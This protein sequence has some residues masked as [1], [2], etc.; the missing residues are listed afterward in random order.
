MARNLFHPIIYSAFLKIKADK[1][2]EITVALVPMAR[3]P[4]QFK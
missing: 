2:V 3:E 1:I 4:E